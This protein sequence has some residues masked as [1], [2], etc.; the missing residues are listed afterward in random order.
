MEGLRGA[1]PREI[2]HLDPLRLKTWADHDCMARVAQVPRQKSRCLYTYIHFNNKANKA[3]TQSKLRY[4]IYDI[5]IWNRNTSSSSLSNANWRAPRPG[6][7]SHSCI[8]CLDRA[9][10]RRSGA[11]SAASETNLARQRFQ[12]I[13]PTRPLRSSPP[14]CSTD[15][16]RT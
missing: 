4:I 13:G 12:P 10:C 8:Q 1:V 11:S 7:T 16:G 5:T 3:I 15:M 6:R 9:T 2:K 14:W